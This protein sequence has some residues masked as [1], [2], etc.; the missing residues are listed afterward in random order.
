MLK[1][2]IIGIFL[3]IL[4]GC[5]SEESSSPSSQNP[6]TPETSPVNVAPNAV[7]EGPASGDERATFNFSGASSS[8]SDGTIASYEWSVDVENPNDNGVEIS[9]DGDSLTISVGE[10]IDN[11]PI[12]ITLLV[13]DNDNQSSSTEFVFTANEVDSQLLPE[14]PDNPDDTLEGV[15]SDNDGIRDDIEIAIYALYPRDKKE[16]EIHRNIAHLYQTIMTMPLSEE[17]IT[18]TSNAIVTSASCVSEFSEFN[19]GI[20]ESVINGLTFNTPERLEKY[21]Q[22]LTRLNGRSFELQTVTEEQ[23]R[24]EENNAD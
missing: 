14:Y 5:G 13:T 12:N 21:D 15:D 22:Y 24:L 4:F 17:M 7:I 6:T 11:L 23:C 16:R 2:F 18:S 9:S 1:L 19:T 20:G 10:I 8:D 3:T